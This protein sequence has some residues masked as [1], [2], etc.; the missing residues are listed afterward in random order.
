MG[1]CWNR[2]CWARGV[3]RAPAEKPRSTIGP[4]QRSPAAT[5]LSA[6]SRLITTISWCQCVRPVAAPSGPVIPPHPETLGIYEL[7]PRT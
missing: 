4:V 1:L 3:T 7:W 2:E 6:G 5:A